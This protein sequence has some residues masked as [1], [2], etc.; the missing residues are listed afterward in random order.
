MRTSIAIVLWLVCTACLS[1]V[2][3]GGRPQNVVAYPETESAAAWRSLASSYVRKALREQKLDRDP[4][5]NA[6]VDTVMAA[7]AQAVAA[8]DPRFARAAWKVILIDEFGLGAVA[9]PGEIILMDAMFVRSLALTDDE[10]ALVLSHEV[11]HVVARHAYEKLSF[12]AET[13]GR[14]KAPT[15]RSALL[16]FLSRD[17]YADAFQPVARL[18]EREADTIGASILFACGY[19]AERALALFDKLASVEARGLRE[20]PDTHDPAPMRKASVSQVLAQLRVAASPRA[21]DRP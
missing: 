4:V 6:R 10:L 15:A 11:A 17:S 20:E 2:P 13:L 12:M 7:V 19:N 16:E 14:D 9:F 18:Q 1:Q 21:A 5:L 8:I 3:P